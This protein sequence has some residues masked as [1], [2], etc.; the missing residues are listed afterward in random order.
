IPTH[1][2][3]AT[4]VHRF[5]LSTA[6]DAEAPAKYGSPPLKPFQPNHSRPAPMATIDV[7]RGIDLA[8]ALQPWPD[9]RRGDEARDARGHVD[10]VAA[11]EVDR[12]LLGEEAA[13]PEAE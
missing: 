6:A 9:D 10:D 5:V 1:T 8:V 12:T 7:V 11:R 13:A 4:A 3:N 2:M